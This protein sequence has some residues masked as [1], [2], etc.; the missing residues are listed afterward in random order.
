MACKYEEIIVPPLKN[1]IEMTDNAYDRI[2]VINQ[3]WKILHTLEYE[4]TFPTAYRFLERF[5]K[6]GN[7]DEQTF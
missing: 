6:L 1:F 4:I 2:Q 7:C 3:E 5:A